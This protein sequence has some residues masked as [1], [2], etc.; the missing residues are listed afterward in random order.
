MKT[1]KTPALRSWLDLV[2]L[3]ARAHRRQNRMTLFCIVLAVSLVATIF[4]MADM[5]LR[6]Q[7]RTAIRTDGNWHVATTDL[8]ADQAAVVAARPDVAA[9]GLYD[10]ANYHLDGGY[11]PVSYTHLTLP[12]NSRV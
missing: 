3:S 10:V 9:V 8:T 1:A 4:A 7:R 6:T 5:E 2:P 12:T 11:T